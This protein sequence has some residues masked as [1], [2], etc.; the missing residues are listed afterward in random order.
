MKRFWMLRVRAWQK[1]K[2][3]NLWQ[4]DHPGRDA[5]LKS[6]ANCEGAESQLLVMLG[7][8]SPARSAKQV[9]ELGH[10]WCWLTMLGWL[11]ELGL[12]LEDAVAAMTDGW[13]QVKENTEPGEPAKDPILL[14]STVWIETKR[15]A[16]ELYRV[17]AR[18]R[19]VPHRESDDLASQPSESARDAEELV[20]HCADRMNA[21]DR[22]TWTAMKR[23]LWAD[24]CVVN[25]Q[26]LAE[27]ELK[28]SRSKMRTRKSAAERAARRIIE[29]VENHENEREL[30][31]LR[32][33]GNRTSPTTITSGG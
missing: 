22:E 7:W 20:A 21:R 30:E 1:A 2:P 12:T 11:L 23:S 9:T 3:Q 27:N 25:Q 13:M 17:P 6:L 14:L 28:C 18:K 16:G 26:S 29:D 31:A 4:S 15:A 24:K 10:V 8:L 32:K 5:E 19:H 33:R